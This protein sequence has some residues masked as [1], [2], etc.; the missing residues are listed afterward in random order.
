MTF[1]EHPRP[2]YFYVAALI[3]FMCVSR[4]DMEETVFQNLSKMWP[5]CILEELTYAALKKGPPRIGFLMCTA[6]EHGCH[7]GSITCVAGLEKKGFS[8]FD[9]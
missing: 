3:L 5:E 7:T 1:P 4:T 6:V 8:P 2:K 9:T